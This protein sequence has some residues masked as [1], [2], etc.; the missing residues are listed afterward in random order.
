MSRV[1]LVESDEG[2]AI[3]APLL[4][5]EPRKKDG[6]VIDDHTPSSISS[7][8]MVSPCNVWLRNSCELFFQR[9]NPVWST[10]LLIQISG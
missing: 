3:E 8:P 9:I 10:L 2:S 4:F 7:R 1:L 6:A 5:I